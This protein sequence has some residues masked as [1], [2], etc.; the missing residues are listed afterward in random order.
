MRTAVTVRASRKA[1][2]TAAEI[3]NRNESNVLDRIPSNSFVNIVSIKFFIKYMP[4]T[5]KTSNKITFKFCC[6][7]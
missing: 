1:D 3:Q 4:A 2:N 7:S 6:I 5:I